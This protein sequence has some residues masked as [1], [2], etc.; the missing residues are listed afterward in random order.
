L[1]KSKPKLKLKGKKTYQNTHGAIYRV[2]SKP[3]Y[4]AIRKS[5]K[6]KQDALNAQPKA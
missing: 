4:K 6:I 3:N 1:P 2:K 5:L